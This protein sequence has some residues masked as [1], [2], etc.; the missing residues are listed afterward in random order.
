[1]TIATE[2]GHPRLHRRIAILNCFCSDRVFAIMMTVLMMLRDCFILT[3]RSLKSVA[4]TLEVTL[5][6]AMSTLDCK[7]GSV[8]CDSDS[9]VV[10]HSTFCI[11]LGSS[12]Q[13]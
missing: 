6:P 3:S 10:E 9:L 13:I 2:W 7:T 1:M 4:T 11:F 8:Y 5:T 12:I